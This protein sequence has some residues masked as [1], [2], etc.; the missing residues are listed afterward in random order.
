VFAG[1]VHPPVF[2]KKTSATQ[3]QWLFVLLLNADCL[4]TVV[5][6]WN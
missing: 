1:S 2:G 6:P 4:I 5:G 3:S